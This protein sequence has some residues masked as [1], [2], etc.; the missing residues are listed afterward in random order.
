VGGWYGR[1][2]KDGS[3]R[4]EEQLAKIIACLEL[5][6]AQRTEQQLAFEKPKIEHQEKERLAKELEERKQQDLINFKKLLID[7]DRWHKAENL[8]RYI[9]EVEVRAAS[10]QSIPPETFKWLEWAKRKA[11]WYDPFIQ[12]PDELLTGADQNT[13]EFPKKPYGYVWGY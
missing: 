4:L 3:T 10:N 9:H 6:A 5:S 8:R 11:D 7:S 2:Y 1:E 12:S 13:L